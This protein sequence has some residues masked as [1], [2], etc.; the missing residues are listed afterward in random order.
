MENQTYYLNQNLA[1]L[2][3]VVVSLTFALI[4]ILH[5]KSYQNLSNYLTAGRNVGPISLTTSIG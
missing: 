1:L 5:S 2:L 3:I 4:G